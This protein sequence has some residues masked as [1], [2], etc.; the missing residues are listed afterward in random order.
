MKAAFVM[1]QSLVSLLLVSTAIATPAT[2]GDSALKEVSAGL[3]RIAEDLK[4]EATVV[5]SNGTVVLS[6]KTRKFMVH[7]TYRDGRR[8]EKA[9][10]ALG[11]QV[12]GLIVRVKLQDGRYDGAAVVPQG[13]RKPYWTTYINAYPVAQGKQYLWVNISFG[14]RTDRDTITRVKQ[15]LASVVDDDPTLKTGDSSAKRTDPPAMEI[16]LV[17]D[18]V[19]F[20]RTKDISFDLIIRNISDKKIDAEKA[21]WGL[22]VVWDGKT[23]WQDPDAPRIWNGPAHILPRSAFRTSFAL[24]E[25][26]IPQLPPPGKHVVWLTGE[27]GQSNRLTVFLK[28]RTEK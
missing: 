14:S 2:P 4:P 20:R 8:V 1:F 23:Y 28:D 26:P 12:D 3:S 24:S 5:G 6:Y 25:H 9:H 21:V 16:V 27:D 22:A 7:G 13:L 17:D 15:L 19:Q 18:K 11:P 10:E